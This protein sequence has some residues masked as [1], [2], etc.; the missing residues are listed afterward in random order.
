MSPVCFV[1]HVPGT[2]RVLPRSRAQGVSS[3]FRASL[4]QTSVALWPFRSACS[5]TSRVGDPPPLATPRWRGPGPRRVCENSHSRTI[6]NQ[7]LRSPPASVRGTPLDFN[8]ICW[9]YVTFQVLFLRG[10][11]LESSLTKSKDVVVALDQNKLNTFMDKF[12][13]ISAP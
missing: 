4:V 7:K 10:S 1:N 9:N 2:Y 6:Q 12:V 13:P 11:N 8:K 5:S 3:I